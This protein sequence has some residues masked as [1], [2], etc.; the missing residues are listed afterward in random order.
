MSIAR[1]PARGGIG[2]PG[3]APGVPTR[4]LEVPLP[5]VE[6]GSEPLIGLFVGE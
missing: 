4:V 3:C 5:L 2:A 1:Y 6:P